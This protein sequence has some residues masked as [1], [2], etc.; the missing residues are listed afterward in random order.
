MIAND[1]MNLWRRIAALVW[2]RRARPVH[3]LA[4]Y[5]QSFNS[6]RIYMEQPQ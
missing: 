6:K 3:L 1:D 5:L 2:R 4:E